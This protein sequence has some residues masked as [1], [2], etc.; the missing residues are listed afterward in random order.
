MPVRSLRTPVLLTI[1]RLIIACT[2]PIYRHGAPVRRRARHPR[3]HTPSRSCIAVETAVKPALE[4]PARRFH[5]P[6]AT[7]N[8]LHR[9]T[10]TG[11]TLPIT[12]SLALYVASERI[13]AI[14]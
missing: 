2:W 4:N 5:R 7:E 13:K 11:M 14:Q 12:P 1:C 8:P 6:L 10:E 9:P 3:F